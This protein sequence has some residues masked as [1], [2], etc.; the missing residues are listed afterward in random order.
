MINAYFH[1]INLLQFIIILFIPSFIIFLFI[2]KQRPF[3]MYFLTKIDK[4]VFMWHISYIIFLIYT[5]MWILK[6]GNEVTLETLSSFNFIPYIEAFV[7]LWL[8]LLYAF[9]VT[10]YKKL[11]F[12]FGF[13]L[14]MFIMNEISEYLKY[15]KLSGVNLQKITHI[16]HFHFFVFT[17]LIYL[18]FFF[19]KIDYLLIF[20][21][22]L[23][24]NETLDPL[25]SLIPYTIIFHIL[26]PLLLVYADELKAANFNN[27]KM[28]RDDYTDDY[29]EDILDFY[30]WIFPYF[31]YFTYLC[32]LFFLVFYLIFF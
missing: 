21:S 1:F 30:D 31:T 4:L 29:I 19:I 27:F 14:K 9:L 13:P 20:I 12:N 16:T 24:F 15:K 2:S 17:S 18:L 23:F 3:F 5:T 8:I 22:F 6:F 10:K 28:D 32:L 7:L 25:A 11:P 26:R